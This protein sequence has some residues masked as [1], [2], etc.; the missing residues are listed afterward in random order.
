MQAIRPTNWRIR[1]FIVENPAI[2]PQEQAQGIHLEALGRK[3][4]QSRYILITA[5]GTNE[6]IIASYP[7]LGED[8]E[9]ARDTLEKVVE[10]LRVSDDLGPGRAW[11]DSQLER[12]KLGELKEINDPKKLTD[13]LADI[14]AVL[15][16]KISVDPKTFD[17]YFH[18]GGV[19]MMI[20]RE[21]AKEKEP[22]WLASSG[23]LQSLLRYAKDI[24]PQ[25]VRTT[26]LENLW[27][28]SKK[29]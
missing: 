12:V 22:E 23:L 19:A 4:G 20:A 16:S 14:E 29:L 3:Y 13:R 6:T 27:L 26:Q 15:L 11:V 7:S 5:K 10:S 2:P 25:D 21:G 8:G 28:E 17:A 18:L 24:A 9:R 1:W